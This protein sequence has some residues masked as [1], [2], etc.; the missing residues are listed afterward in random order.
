MFV[1]S[2]DDEYSF[3][4]GF[5]VIAGRVSGEDGVRFVVIAIVPGGIV[6]WILDELEQLLLAVCTVKVAAGDEID[7]S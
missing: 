4:N 1:R 6:V 3:T 5:K 7:A 2:I